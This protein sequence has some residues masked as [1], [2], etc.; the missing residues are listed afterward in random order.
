MPDKIEIDGKIYNS[1]RKEELGILDLAPPGWKPE[2]ETVSCYV[3]K[4]QAYIQKLKQCKE[5]WLYTISPSLYFFKN[6]VL[7]F[8]RGY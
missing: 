8:L 6:K 1:W 7:N 4:R 5:P 2:C 3:S